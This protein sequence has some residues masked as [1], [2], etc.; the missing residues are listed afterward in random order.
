MENFKDI[1]EP[2][3]NRKDI[4]FLDD[5]D[6][7][8]KNVCIVTGAGNGIGRAVAVAAAANGLM[9]LGLDI[10]QQ[11]GNE[12]VKIAQAMGGQ[13]EFVQ[14]DLTKD[15]DIENAVNKATQIGNIV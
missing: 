9:T 13:M 1:S 5:P 8:S 14:A 2:S 12:T 11:T 4:L 10:N 6:F 15:E 7:N 3:I